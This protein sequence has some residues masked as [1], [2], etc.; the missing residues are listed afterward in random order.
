[1]KIFNTKCGDITSI[2]IF[3]LLLKKQHRRLIFLEAAGS[4]ISSIFLQKFQ[5]GVAAVAGALS[6]LQVNGLCQIPSYH[7]AELPG[8]VRYGTVQ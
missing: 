1:M 7:A 5:K 4:D 6:L 8:L 3:P 2:C